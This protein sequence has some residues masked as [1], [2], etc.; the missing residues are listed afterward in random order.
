MVA[1][2][3]EY[4]QIAEGHELMLNEVRPRI[5]EILADSRLRMGVAIVLVK[6]VN[7]AIVAEVPIESGVRR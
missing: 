6:S 5:R 2:L 7:G 1:D 3:Q 4:R